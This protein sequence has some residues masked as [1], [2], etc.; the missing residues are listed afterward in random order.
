MN[1]VSPTESQH[2]QDG[3]PAPGKLS[4][5]IPTL[6]RETVLRTVETLLATYGGGKLEIVVSG[7]IAK[8]DVLSRLRE[9][10]GRHANVRHLE[11]QFETGDTS[12]KKNVGVQ[13]THGEFVAFVD[14]DVEVAEDWPERI[15]A[16]FAD[17][18]VGLASGPGL[19]P[20]G[21]TE[22][23]RQA[24]LALSSRAAGY[25][26]KRYLEGG[27]SAYSI[28]WDEI[29]GCNQA[30]RRKTFDEMGGF[31]PDCIPGEEMLAAFRTQRLGW[32][33]RFVPG[34][35]VWHWPRQSLGR[36]WRQMWRYG[37]ARIRLM[38][39]GAE[40][41]LSTLVPGL[42]VGTTAV[43][44]VAGFRWPIAWWLLGAELA[45]YAILSLAFALETIWLTR[46]WGDWRLWPMIWF[47]HTAY[48]LGEW[49]ELCRPAR[50]LSDAP[51][52][53]GT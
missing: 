53:P 49:L 10:I 51:D 15:L 31:P 23:G 4:V 35:R 46:R 11:V 42:W 5:V 16:P 28:G 52:M 13:E 12:L 45:L 18:H 44:A 32:K 14:D 8:P 36:F 38:R 24:G 6:G 19:V 33:I 22:A 26:A 43:L 39:K 7:K 34:A 30:Y 47:M 48:G 3:I 20:D 21:L 17:E 2:T 9:I 41:H 40:W 37:A 25:V 27:T 50:D 29:I 1:P